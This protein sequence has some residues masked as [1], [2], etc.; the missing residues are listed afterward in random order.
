MKHRNKASADAAA[1]IQVAR[2]ASSYELLKAQNPSLNPIELLNKAIDETPVTRETEL[3][4]FQPT[5]KMKWRHPI[6][7]S[8]YVALS[9]NIKE[10]FSEH[11]VDSFSNERMF[12]LERLRSLLEFGTH[13]DRMYLKHVTFQTGDRELITRL[14]QA[15]KSFGAVVDEDGQIFAATLNIK[16]L[17]LVQSVITILALFQVFCVWNFIREAQST[18]CQNCVLLG[19]AIVFFL[20]F[21]GISFLWELGP[22]RAKYA[23]ALLELGFKDFWKQP[24]S[25][26]RK[27]W[28][29]QL[30]GPQQTV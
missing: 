3:V 26:R 25:T 24:D 4:A 12:E 6:I 18:L 16:L 15:L 13:I 23:K 20:C 30:I 9:K 22:S 29:L 11:G 27:F 1:L 14:R 8:R 7:A 5:L 17:L 28:K 21:I 10:D 19:S 2:T